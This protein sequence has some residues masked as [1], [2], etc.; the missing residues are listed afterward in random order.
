MVGRGPGFHNAKRLRMGKIFLPESKTWDLPAVSHARLPDRS[1]LACGYQ[2]Y[3]GSGYQYELSS[4]ECPPGNQLLDFQLE[5]SRRIKLQCFEWNSF[6]G[7]EFQWK[8][9]IG[10]RC[11]QCKR[12]HIH[13]A[14]CGILECSPFSGYGS[15]LGASIG[16]TKRKHC[17]GID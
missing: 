7:T 12:V 5:S 9:L 13:D 15:R 2:C 17:W 16:G 8:F 14:A 10:S 4:S 11:F 3:G 6:R 1:G